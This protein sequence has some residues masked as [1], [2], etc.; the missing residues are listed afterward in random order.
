MEDKLSPHTSCFPVEE[1]LLKYESNSWVYVARLLLGL[2][3]ET[4]FLAKGVVVF[5]SILIHKRR[6][7]L[8]GGGLQFFLGGKGEEQEESLHP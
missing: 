7:C 4:Y 1:L 2:L 3:L 8:Q 5:W 6:F